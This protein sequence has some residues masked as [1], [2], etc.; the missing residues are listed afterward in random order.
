[1]PAAMRPHGNRETWESEIYFTD[2]ILTGRESSFSSDIG[3]RQAPPNR[4]LQLRHQIYFTYNILTGRKSPSWSDIGSRW[5]PPT[6]PLQL[7]RQIYFT[8]N[9]LTGRKSPF[10]SDIGSREAL[11]FVCGRL[12][13]QIYFTYNILTGR[14]ILRLSNG[15]VVG[16][17]DDNPPSSRRDLTAKMF[18]TRKSQP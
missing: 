6:R 13:R 11:Q 8:Y 9:I 17:T 10:S 12:G 3:S 2:N 4:P 7:R 15:T 14:R 1:M 16:L 5:A 18:R